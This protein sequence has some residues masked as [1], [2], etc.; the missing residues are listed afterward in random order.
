MPSA[1]TRKTTNFRPSQMKTDD[2]FLR[3]SSP[4]TVTRM[5]Q[6]EGGVHNGT[7]SNPDEV[8]FLRL[9]E[10]RAMT[11]LSKSCLYLLIRE[12]SFPNS[13][14]IGNRAVGWVRS[15]VR[16]WALERINAP[17]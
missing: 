11:G 13:V 4:Q 6:S 16:Q 10:V 5:L 3:S 2:Q 1:T 14:R 9:A 7:L 17:R 8:T 15:A 12:G